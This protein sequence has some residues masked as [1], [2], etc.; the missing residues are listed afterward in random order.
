MLSVQINFSNS[1]SN[2]EKIQ[3]MHSV[4][5]NSQSHCS[6]QVCEIAM[7]LSN[8][9]LNPLFRF[10]N[11]TNYFFYVGCLSEIL[12]WANDFYNQFYKNRLIIEVSEKTDQHSN[13]NAI[14]E[15]FLIAWGQ[16]RLEQFFNRNPD[17]AGLYRN[18]AG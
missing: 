12:D 18:E 15:E 2:P 8:N 4:N 16:K 10:C 6:E 11:G 9:F 1:N 7:C 14:T 5:Y 3:A 17:K 13:T